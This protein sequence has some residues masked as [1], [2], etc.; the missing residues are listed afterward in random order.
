MS[1]SLLACFLRTG[2]QTGH[3]NFEVAGS[4]PAR[5]HG[6]WHKYG[7]NAGP[8]SASMHHIVRVPVQQGLEAG[9][10]AEGVPGGI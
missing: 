7:H 4:V 5:I 9:M 1:P 8:N 2:N 10:V 6:L 3:P